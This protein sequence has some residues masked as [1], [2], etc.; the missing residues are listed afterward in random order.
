MEPS[1]RFR[2][3]SGMFFDVGMVRSALKGDIEGD[4]NFVV[5]WRFQPAAENP[6]SSQFGVDGF[7]A[8]FAGTNGPG[9]AGF[10]GLAFRII[11]L[12][13]PKRF[14]DGMDGRQ[15]ENIKTHF[16]DSRQGRLAI[17]ERA[18]LPSAPSERGKSS[19]HALKRASGGSTVTRSSCA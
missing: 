16:G 18:V 2:N 4:F 12:S 6:R 14:A 3:H 19:Y 9:A 1:G 15:I 11:V 10:A 17:F 5:R 7:M 13:F 8:A